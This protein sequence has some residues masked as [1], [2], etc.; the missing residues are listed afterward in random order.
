MA[1]DV[2]ICDRCSDNFV[3]KT[4]KI[5]CFS[6]KKYFHSHCVRVKDDCLKFINR[7]DSV[8]WFCDD[9]KVLLP[10]KLVGVVPEKTEYESLKRENS[11]LSSLN[12][13][14]KCSN[15][16]LKE[17]LGMI[18]NSNNSGSGVSTNISSN[19]QNQLASYS[20]ALKNTSTNKPGLVIKSQGSSINND[21]VLKDIQK[22]IHPGDKNIRIDSIK[23]V[24][25]G[26]IVNCEND[27]SLKNLKSCV[28]NALGSKY[29]V[30]Q[31]N[32]FNPRLILKDVNLND[33]Q[34]NDD[35]LNEIFTLNDLIDN[36]SLNEMKI[37]AVLNFNNKS[38]IIFETTP[39]LRKCIIA[40]GFL[41]VGWKKCFVNDHLR[42]IKCKKCHSFGHTEKTC[43]STVKCIMCSNDHDSKQCNSTHR[44]CINCTS[45]NNKFRTKFD[46]NHSAN[47]KAC[48]V[49]K[50]YIQHLQ[51]KINYG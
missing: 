40:K 27:D 17:K 5:Q 24:R 44:K 41:Y 42:I 39:N 6:C 20:S 34:P 30:E 9:C 2:V 13:E 28:N 4:S 19:S 31:I 8:F 1:G 46:T 18:I 22:H 10:Q 16:L 35:L 32:K 23:K 45:N 48:L 3:V 21:D 43:T 36:F 51:S 50:N 25:G 38:N 33:K 12:S 26:I 14:L 49:Y 37:V 7:S 11:L 29:S 15:E 47:D